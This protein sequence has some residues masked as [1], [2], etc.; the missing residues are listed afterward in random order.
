L[1]VA[2]QLGWETGGADVTAWSRW[3][4]ALFAAAL[5][6]VV[7]LLVWGV[8]SRRGERRLRLSAEHGD[9]TVPLSALQRLV[10]AAALRHPDVVSAEARL[11]AAGGAPGGRLR[12][13]VRPMADTAVV[14]ADVEAQARAALDQV[15]GRETAQ[16]SVTTEVLSVRQL[17]ERLQ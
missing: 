12:L 5:C 3:L 13:R 6:A 10:V 9:V 17:G 8:V 7:S 1:L 15:I 4:R 11:R 14:A 2:A 16:L